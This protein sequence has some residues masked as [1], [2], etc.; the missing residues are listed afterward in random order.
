M[1]F[2]TAWQR[3]VEGEV[4]D[5]YQSL[6]TA[7]KSASWPEPQGDDP[8]GLTLSDGQTRCAGCL[9]VDD[10]ACA[11]Y[12]AA[13]FAGVLWP[14]RTEERQEWKAV[15]EDTRPEWRASYEGE[16]TAY[17]RIHEMLTAAETPDVLGVYAE[18]PHDGTLA[19]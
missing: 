16:A 10:G 15:I 1:A 12:G 14:H 9:Y 3:A 19:A 7:D 18:A 4:C 17:S 8:P 5:S 13:I 6:R 2:A 11:L